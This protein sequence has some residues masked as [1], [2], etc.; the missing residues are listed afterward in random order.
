MSLSDINVF[1]IQ[2]R[3]IHKSLGIECY[4][5]FNLP[6]ELGNMDKVFISLTKQR[7]EVIGEVVNG[8]ERM[9]WS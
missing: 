8:V 7:G 4:A 9:F 5:I 2:S 6:N 3:K 1:I